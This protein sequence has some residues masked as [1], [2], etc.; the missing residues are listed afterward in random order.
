MH[1]F[2]HT[3]HTCFYILNPSFPFERQNDVEPTIK[4]TSE[5]ECG[6]PSMDKHL[7]S[8]LFLLYNIQLKTAICECAQHVFSLAA[9]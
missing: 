9:N 2:I 8:C 5:Q 7:R 6:K 4:D 3:I 1:N